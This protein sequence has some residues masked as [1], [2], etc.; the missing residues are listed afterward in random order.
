MGKTRAYGPGFCL[1]GDKLAQT[2]AVRQAA[3]T[4][5]R[6]KAFST[7]GK[8][9]FSNQVLNMSPTAIASLL[10]SAGVPVTK[11]MV[12]TAD[13]AQII[14]SGGAFISNVETASSISSYA[15]PTAA[16][17]QGALDVMGQMG[18]IDS[19]SPL[20][21]ILMLGTDI[22]M[23]I[24]GGGANVLADIKLV[25]DIIEMGFLAP[26][27]QAYANMELSKFIQVRHRM[28]T[29]AI[30]NNFKAYHEGKLSVFGLMG[31]VAEES[32]DY[33][34]NYFPDQGI[35]FPPATQTFW[36]DSET[37]SGLGTTVQSA[38]AQ[39]TVN[40]ILFSDHATVQRTIWDKIVNPTLLHYKRLQDQETSLNKISVQNLALLSMMPPFI[41]QFPYK[42][43]ATLLL[44]K[45][46]LSPD[47][48]C[49]GV[50][51]DFLLSK[52]AK[53]NNPSPI[54]YN[55]VDFFTNSR[56]KVRSLNRQE[57]KLIDADQN[58]RIDLLMQDK[59]AGHFISEWAKPAWIGVPFPGTLPSNGKTFYTKTISDEMITLQQRNFQNYWASLSIIEQIRN[60]QYFSDMR[61][62]I[63]VYDFLTSLDDMNKRHQQLLFK[64]QTRGL[65]QMAY[66]NIAGF[67]G[68]DVRN[69]KLV[70]RAE[71]GQPA[72]FQ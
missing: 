31:K 32:P 41:N 51:S 1:L 7:I 62:Q 10:K 25:M 48:L 63:Q 46:R 42:F 55:G 18:W 56:P 45:F 34:L 66:K 21:Q 68:I 64:V 12:I 23:V 36:Y 26:D 3:Q 14:V 6:V 50:V 54:T 27:A 17:L 60:D 9:L 59:D 19:K 70:R 69:L 71:N 2:T 61:N 53:E 44:K 5:S 37:S 40:T 65:N 57:Q 13:M 38:H 29:D 72:I 33:F 35:F 58:G 15:S 11:E 52:M 8:K 20:A 43:D 39:T 49:S 67:L 28:Q 24:A 16:M 30:S 47:D 22:A 4:A